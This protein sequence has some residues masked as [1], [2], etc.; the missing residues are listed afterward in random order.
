M[1]TYADAVDRL[2]R[3]L[4]G[5]PSDS[6]LSDC[7]EAAQAALGTLATAHT[8]SY[9]HTYGRVDTHAPFTAGTVTYDHED[10]AR[11]RLLTL[12][13][14][15][16]PDWAA[17]GVIRID[18]LPHRIEAR[19]SATTVTLE[20]SSC[21]AGDIAAPAPFRLSRDTFPL[22]ADYT[23]QDAT[24]I[25]GNFGGLAYAHPREWFDRVDRLDQ[26]GTP[27]IY[28]VMGDRRYPGRLVIR[29]APVPDAPL[30]IDFLYRRSPRPLR[31][32]ED[33]GLAS[34]S[35]GDAGVIGAATT[36]SDRHEGS[37]FRLGATERAPTSATGSNPPLVEALVAAVIDAEHLDLAEPAR[38]TLESRRFTIS[39]PI[40]IEPGSMQNAYLRC[41]EMHLGMSR[42]LKD[43]PSARAQYLES[44]ERARSADSRSF[45]GRSPQPSG[46]VVRTPASRIIAPT[47]EE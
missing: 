45:T 8:W 19:L 29:V 6:V 27:A 14:G 44:L 16:W 3:Y 31:V 25:P 40:D 41:A 11:P 17:D 15:I 37:V 47:F 21:P 38:A 36:W 1:L 20:E 24:A 18:G 13:G 46:R 4:G 10:G 28:S 2:I 7:K 43:K 39:D 22:P 34:S 33:V 30:A 26:L 42:V 5:S 35:A 9:L 32:F 12:A 23:A